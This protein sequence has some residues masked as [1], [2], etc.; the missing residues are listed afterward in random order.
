M[1]SNLP[2]PD[3]L[4]ESSKKYALSALKVL[5]T[6]DQDRFSLYAGIALE[7]LTKACLA[8]AHPALLLELRNDASNEESLFILTGITHI[9]SSQLRTVSMN[10]ALRRVKKLFESQ[11]PPIVSRAIWGDLIKLVEYRNGHAHLANSESENNEIFIAFVQQTETSLRYLSADRNDFWNV[12]IKVVDNALSK[13]VDKVTRD[14]ELKMSQSRVLWQD[15]LSTL[16]ED[17]LSIMRDTRTLPNTNEEIRRC[18]VCKSFG[19]AEGTHSM[20]YDIDEDYQMSGQWV[21]FIPK[22]FRCPTC[23]LSLNSLSECIEAGLDEVWDSDMKPE[24]FISDF[25][26]DDEGIPDYGD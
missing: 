23:S 18:P 20:A 12:M 15:R 25:Y 14:V 11:V 4:Y 7:H 10:S 26:E 2:T 22:R 21:E 24:D 19:I 1:P 16:G 3:I 17:H 6:S 5:E 9:S 13:N 8:Q